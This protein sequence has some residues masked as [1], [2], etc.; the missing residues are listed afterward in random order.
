VTTSIGPLT[1]LMHCPPAPDADPA[2]PPVANCH[3]PQTA[4][5]IAA[6]RAAGVLAAKSR[7]D[8]AGVARLMGTFPSDPAMA[9][10]FLLLA[11]L[12][13]GLYREQTRRSVEECVHELCLQLAASVE[14]I[15]AAD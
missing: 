8:S 14:Q 12:T 5:K 3:G 11:E 2:I 7:G 15:V 4:Q 6:Q 9:G 13:L 10:G 1:C